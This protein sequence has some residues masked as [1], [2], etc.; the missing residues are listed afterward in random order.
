MI[1]RIQVDEALTLDDFAAV[2]HL[3]PAVQRLR[4][5]AANRVPGFK[6]RTLWMVSST[7]HGGGVAEMMPR[8]VSILRELGIATEWV[9]MRPKQA[10][11]FRSHQTTSQPHS[12]CRNARSPIPQDR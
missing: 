1:E 6:D 4:D 11:F 9:V 12:R 2:A 8:L 5:E 7:E 3:S 10:G